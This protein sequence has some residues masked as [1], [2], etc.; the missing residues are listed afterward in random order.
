M[1]LKSKIAAITLGIFVLFG[2]VF[3]G[4][5]RFIIFPSF[6][7]LE[8][9]VAITDI[10]RSVKS[11]QLVI[12][13]LDSFCWDWA[14]WDE[15]Y[16][17]IQTRSEAYIKSNLV[18]ET[19]SDDDINVIYFVD[20]SGRVIWGETRD[21]KAELTRLVEFPADALPAGHPL[22][23]HN[24]ENKPLKEVSIAG[25]YMTAKGPMVVSSRP[26]LTNQ[27]RGPIRG[28]VILGQ[29]LNEKIIAEL[30]EQTQID[31]HVYPIMDGTLTEPQKKI[32]D[33]LTAQS[34]YLI[35]SAGADYFDAYTL[36]ADIKGDAALLLNV[37]I[38]RNIS[39]SGY[40]SMRYA[41]FLFLAA[42]SGLLIAMY[43]LLH[44]SVFKPI[45]NFTRHVKSIEKSSD[46]S[47]AFPAKRRD[48]IGILASEFNRMLA[49]LRGFQA[50]LELQVKE[51]T[52]DLTSAN[53]RLYR[54]MLER[55][56]AE[57]EA[58]TSEE[59]LARSKRMESI[60]LMAGGIAH[61]LNNILAGIV[62]YPDL[63][64]LDLPEQ[65]PLR[66][67][68]EIMKESAER[69]ADVVADLLTVARG[70]AAAK[71]VVNLNSI[72]EEYLSSAEHKQVEATHL[73][74]TLETRLDPNLL[75]IACSSVHIKKCLLNLI[76]NAYESIEDSGNITLSTRN[77]YLDEPLAGY[78]DVR[79][80][81]YALLTVTDNGSGISADDIERIFEPF[82][83]KKTMGRSGTGLGLTV[84]WNTVKSHEGYVNVKS[85]QEGSRFE[86]FFPITRDEST[87][88]REHSLFEDYVGNGESI[89]VVDDEEM[90]RDITCRLLTKLGYSATAVSSGEEAIDYLR[91]QAVDLIVLDM[92]MPQG[93]NGRET[94][95]EI[96]KLWP[97]QKAVI[98]SGFAES[99]DVKAA[100]KLGAGKY[101]KKPYTLETIGIALKK[102]LGN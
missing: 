25:I 1:T 53:E 20:T 72:V 101:I 18:L 21:R 93:M 76:V 100:Q 48:E 33:R 92:I 24:L 90:Q 70:A 75:N 89:L 59:K 28:S 94:Y 35:E 61:D 74:T 66:Q 12:D 34:R 50:E 55:R 80:G 87:V 8:R 37:R 86:L 32:A 40:A 58:R 11:L 97:N 88:G 36:F 57:E 23:A 56:Q 42:G 6:L 13:T 84:V 60:G 67:P 43:L 51:R 52:A 95:E 71:E 96:I 85:W 102:E 65:N 99:E 27:S 46:L 81:E 7:A 17:F 73:S 41:I 69:A 44:F 3:F 68:V 22:L 54:E 83:T 2:G 5:Q 78:E 15:T 64:L 45:Q 82:Y 98:A 62:S 10:N 79:M 38:P 39:A 9:E 47:A 77:F 26:I 29:Y 63:L 31:F 16:D 19:F 30:V 14:A 49:K 91:E 4:V